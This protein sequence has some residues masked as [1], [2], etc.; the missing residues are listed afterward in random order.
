MNKNFKKNFKK[1]TS[2]VLASSMVVSMTLAGSMSGV[3]AA[4]NGTS[5]KINLPDVGTAVSYYWID[6]DVSLTQTHAID[7]GTYNVDDSYDFYIEYRPNYTGTNV[8]KKA[9]VIDAVDNNEDYNVSTSVLSGVDGFTGINARK[10]NFD[11]I[12]TNNY[13]YNLGVSLVDANQ[14]AI[15]NP[16][17]CNYLTSKV[18]VDGTESLSV[19]GSSTTVTSGS[20]YVKDNAV[21]KATASISDPGEVH[22]I[23]GM[24]IGSSLDETTGV[25]YNYASDDITVNNNVIFVSDVR[26]AIQITNQTG[27]GVN[28]YVDQNPENDSTLGGT[29]TTLYAPG[30]TSRY[31]RQAQHDVYLLPNDDKT[32][33]S[34]TFNGSTANVTTTS[35]PVTFKTPVLTANATLTA[36]TAKVTGANE[37]SRPLGWADETNATTTA[38][39]ATTQSITY[40]QLVNGT[41]GELAP[42]TDSNY[43]GFNWNAKIYGNVVG[44]E[45]YSSWYTY[46]TQLTNPSYTFKNIKAGTQYPTFEGANTSL[47]VGHDFSDEELAITNAYMP[48]LPANYKQDVTA[49]FTT[50]SWICNNHWWHIGGLKTY[51]DANATRTVTVEKDIPYAS[52]SNK[53]AGVTTTSKQREP[54]VIDF[55]YDGTS[56][57]LNQLVM[58]ASTLNKYGQAQDTDNEF[59]DGNGYIRT[60]DEDEWKVTIS[61]TEVDGTEIESQT[62]YTKADGT[63]DIASI[64]PTNAGSYT[65]E[66]EH[67]SNSFVA[68]GNFTFTF[69][70]LPRK[71]DVVVEQT[72][73]TKVYGTVDPTITAEVTDVTGTLD[74]MATGGTISL[75]NGVVSYNGHTELGTDYRPVFN[76]IRETGEDVGSYDIT[77]ELTEATDKNY[78]I[79]VLTPGTFDIT[80]RSLN[81]YYDDSFKFYGEEDS[82]LAIIVEDNTATEGAKLLDSYYRNDEA[83]FVSD[84]DLDIT[85]KGVNPKTALPVFTITREAGEDVTSGYNAETGELTYENGYD[86]KAVADDK[87]KANYAITFATD[88]NDAFEVLP[89]FISLDFEDQTKAYGVSDAKSLTYQVTDDT[90]E[91]LDSW[92]DQADEGTLDWYEFIGLKVTKDVTGTYKKGEDASKTPLIEGCENP[93]ITFTREKGEDIGEYAL[94]ASTNEN[95]DNNY[96]VDALTINDEEILD[97]D[98]VLNEDETVNVGKLVI[99]QR[100]IALVIDDQSKKVGQKDPTFTYH[101]ADL[102][103]DPTGKTFLT[104]AD[105]CEGAYLPVV[106]LVRVAGE[107]AGTYTISDPD[108]AKNNPNYATKVLNSTQAITDTETKAS[109]LTIATGDD[110]AIA[111]FAVLAIVSALGA[112]MIRRKK[113]LE[114]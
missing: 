59:F 50:A 68:K 3:S 97:L 4:V 10:I 1:I 98:E 60:D 29:A 83:G 41:S 106:N 8:Q 47:A 5:L 114:E 75:T 73:N 39:N 6:P 53:T 24:Y 9:V 100:N 22:Y 7:P 105:L 34:Y 113:A 19:T 51:T 45:Y 15:T 96:L 42:T 85:T 80:K 64:A 30:A 95:T 63:I 12:D 82:A 61:G 16:V 108:F 72:G 23:H 26:N 31:L 49:T 110:T 88:D 93:V 17:S 67:R 111:A 94:K 36:T 55:A 28:M 71:L 25:A 92:Y 20:I 70:I 43:H 14:V 27:S 56:N 90:K 79:N 107:K 44:N 18:L 2:S 33:N 101:F 86:V 84:V 112:L 74:T 91:L 89:R 58:R 35:L 32:I 48:Y 62:V 13:E 52:L 77:V 76:V 102:E 38:G 69:N 87:T 54:Q 57:Y 37:S 81:V 65:M 109:V 99:R 11:T 21:I 46:G 104:Q 103:M 40:S 78:D 66:I